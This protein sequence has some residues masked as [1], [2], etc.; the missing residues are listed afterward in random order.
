MANALK[1]ITTRAKQ[2][3]ESHPNTEW[4]L[5]VKRAAAELRKGKKTFPQR[6]TS[7]E[8]IDRARKAKPPGYRKSASRK[9]YFES[10]K[11]R[12]D[13]PGKLTGVSLTSLKAE[14]R[15]KINE[16]I[17]KLVVKKFRE[18]KKRVRAKIQKEISAAKAELKKFS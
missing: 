1:K 7:N 4:K 10:R 17:D 11:N 14:A 15:R 6:G 2:L 13:A 5:L 9:K 3:R 8:E 18:T 16:K 12:S